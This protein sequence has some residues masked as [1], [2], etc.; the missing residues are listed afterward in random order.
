MKTFFKNKKIYQLSP[1]QFVLRILGYSLLVL[2]TALTTS[3]H[4]KQNELQGYIEARLAFISSNSPGVLQ[5]LYV[6]RGDQVTPGQPLFSLEAQPESDTYMQAKADLDNALAAQAEA[7][8][9][10]AHEKLLLDRRQVLLSKQVLD[11]ET[12]DNATINYKD[13][14]TKLAAADAKVDAARAN[15]QHAAWS[16]SQKSIISDQTGTVF[17]TYF[18]PSELV[19]EK[20]PVVSLIL[21]K[22]I[23]VIFFVKEPQLSSINVGEIIQVKCDGYDKLVPAKI[24]FIS[25]RAELTPP[26][27]YT[28][29]ERT[30]FVYRV[31]A[32]RTTAD[33][34]CFHPGQP[35]TVVLK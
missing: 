16:K 27:L 8:A 30:K 14:L 31:E 25:P 3:C 17:D 18:L 10:V 12:V 4:R 1:K 26:V 20:Q 32:D 19:P 2:I 9:N 5:Q 22:E 35:V 13:A 21:P 23:R 34:N 15:L 29:K 11:T 28:T 7:Q 6:K 24:S 33:I